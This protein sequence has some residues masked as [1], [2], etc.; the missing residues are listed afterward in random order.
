[1]EETSGEIITNSIGMKMTLIPAGGFMM[2]SPD[3][4]WR[5]ESDERP[6]HHVEIT[7]S[8]HLGVYPVTQAEYEKVMGGT[9][10]CFKD[11]DHNPVEG[12]TWFDAVAFCNKMSEVEKI[13][14]FYE[15]SEEAVSI[16]GGN[17]YRLPT[18]AEWEYAC[19]AGTTTKWFFGDKESR[20][21][22]YAWCE[23]PWYD[24]K[25]NG[26]N[27][28][29]PVGEKKPNPWGL[30]DMHGNVWEWCWDWYGDFRASPANDPNGPT[31]G[32]VRVLR[33][34][35]FFDGSLVVRSAS[36]RSYQPT[37]RFPMI[38]FRLARTLPIVPLTSLPPT[39]R[40]GERN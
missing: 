16:V 4:E 12:V 15:I 40:L 26:G 7:K 33:G 10:S 5:A 38:G 18:E 28:T 8:F 39:A 11:K 13:E 1:M 24:R 22:E 6:Q 32:E 3:S 9:P 21:K 29:H 30:H 36:R 20:L 25:H 2:G 37:F 14:P 34:G 19:R 23:Y 35:S 17:G 27:T 31:T